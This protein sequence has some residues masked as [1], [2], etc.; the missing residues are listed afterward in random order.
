M[1]AAREKRGPRAGEPSRGMV[2]GTYR[3]LT[4][5][6]A[7]R[8]AR[9]AGAR[10]PLVATVELYLDARGAARAHEQAPVRAEGPVR[11]GGLAA[12]ID[13]LEEAGARRRR[14]ELDLEPQARRERGGAQA[15][16]AVLG[17]QGQGRERAGARQ[18]RRARAEEP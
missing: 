4:G 17:A 8:D 12:R 7:Q 6:R 10:A 18:P 9:I 11:V 13:D 15:P 14:L 1:T 2:D 5:P 16:G 3:T